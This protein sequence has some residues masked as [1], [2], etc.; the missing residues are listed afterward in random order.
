MA[1][2]GQL[3]LDSGNHFR[4]Q[5][6]GVQYRDAAS[7]VDQFAAFNV[8]HRR[9]LRGIDEDRVDLA[10]ATWDGVDATLHQGFVGFAHSV[11]NSPPQ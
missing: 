4:V 9:V 2:L 3:F 1:D 11:L 5:V 7:E 6:A 8:N 10:N